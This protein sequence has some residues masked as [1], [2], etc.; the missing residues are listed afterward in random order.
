[1]SRWLTVAAVRRDSIGD[2]AMNRKQTHRSGASTLPGVQAQRGRNGTQSFR[3]NLRFALA[4][5]RQFSLY[6]PAS[7]ATVG[8]KWRAV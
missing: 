5:D 2:K 3:T 1:M 8:E 6:D 7:P 4:S